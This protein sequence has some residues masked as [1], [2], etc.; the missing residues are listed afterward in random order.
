MNTGGGNFVDVSDESGDGLT[1][2]HASRGTGFN[3]LDNDGDIDV[4]VV[5]S[6][7]RPN[8]LR[9]DSQPKAGGQAHW[10][11]LELIGIQSN[12][13]GVG[14]RVIVTAGD[15]I[16]TAE[17]HSGRGYQSHHAMRL[18]FGLGAHTT[19]DQLEI[20]WE[21]SGT[22]DT[23]KDVPVDQLHHIIEGRGLEH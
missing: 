16:Q 2:V 12:R 1:P 3:D 9:N 13:D 14:S 11:E 18:H 7:E 19:I 23:F 10:V 5:N 6:R 22:H 8:L 21:G 20:H 15:L 17:V 4:V